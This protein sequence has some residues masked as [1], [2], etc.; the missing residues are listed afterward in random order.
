MKKLISLMLVVVMVL[1]FAACGKKTENNSDVTLTWMVPYSEQADEELVEA[2]ISKITKEKLGVS[3]DLQFIDTAAY[4]ER[5]TMNMA[6]GKDFDLCFTGYVNPYIQNVDNGGYLDITDLLK[7]KAPKLYESYP[8][9]AWDIATVDGRIY[10]VPNLQGFAPPTSFWT[11]KEL[12]DKYNFDFEAMTKPEDVEPFLKTIKENEPNLYG[13]RTNYNY[14]V[15]TNGVYEEITADIGIKVDGSSPKVVYIRDTP[16]YKKAIM[17]M[18][19]W[20]KKGYIRPDLL[21]VGNDTQDYNAGKYAVSVGGWLPGSEATKSKQFETEYIAVPI[22]KSVLSKQKSLAAM[23]AIGRNSKHPE[24]AIKLL[25]LINTDQELMTLFA[26]GIE[27]KHY[28]LDE[29]GKYEKING[30][31]YTT[32]GEWLFGN[33]FIGKLA[34]GQADDTW[35]AT[36]QMNLDAIASPILGFTLKTDDIKTIISQVEAAGAEYTEAQAVINGNADHEKMMARKREAGLDKLM[37]EVQK[38][39][40]AYWAENN[41]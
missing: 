12:A 41:K 8:E 2:E 26:L 11:S 15:W 28:T 32:S 37:A 23:T 30:S 17:T 34:V 1:S 31:G 35:E 25:E 24:E 29:S 5:M 36:K 19:D 13:Y 21:S 33:Q 38:Q 10:G 3:V 6:S 16:E 18:H 40:D 22:C 9:Y 7:E 27:G 39:I 4:T 20:F 14:E